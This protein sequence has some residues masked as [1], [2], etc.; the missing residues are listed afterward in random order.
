MV[1]NNETGVI[2]SD[3]DLSDVHSSTTV[4]EMISARAEK[5]ADK[6]AV[7]GASCVDQSLTYHELDTRS[8]MLAHRL[9][10]MGVGSGELVGLC[11]ERS[12]DMLVGLL[13]VLKAKPNARPHLTIGV[14]KSSS[15]VSISPKFRLC[16]GPCCV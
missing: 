4:H 1:G 10:G 9:R 12:L 14:P 7:G 11:V 5:S 3:H 13:G 8:N 6:I 2:D 15:F 16:A